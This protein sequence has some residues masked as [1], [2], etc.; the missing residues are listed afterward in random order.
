MNKADLI[1]KI[2]LRADL[3]KAKASEALDAMLIEIVLA[4]KKGDDVRLTGFG[5]FS[6]V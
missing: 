5:T 1:E 2:A 4:V 3:S 6:S